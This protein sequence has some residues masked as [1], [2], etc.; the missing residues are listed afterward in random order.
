MKIEREGRF[1][2]LTDAEMQAAFRECLLDKLREEIRN[3]AGC[4]MMPV[5][6]AGAIKG[7]KPEEIEALL[8]EAAE[9]LYG[10][11]DMLDNVQEIIWYA[12]MDS[13]AEVIRLRKEREEK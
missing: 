8:S 3:A 1:F 10:H 13:V 12:G 4:G 2:E 5:K 9:Y 6:P 7:M 11:L